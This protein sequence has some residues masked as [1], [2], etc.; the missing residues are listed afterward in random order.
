[1]LLRMATTDLRLEEWQSLIFFE[2]QRP[3]S[4]RYWPALICDPSTTSWPVVCSFSFLGITKGGLPWHKHFSN[5]GG[6]IDEDRSYTV[7]V[8]AAL[9]AHAATVAWILLLW[10]PRTQSLTPAGQLYPGGFSR[11]RRPLVLLAGRV[12]YRAS[13]PASTSIVQQ[14]TC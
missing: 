5:L 10:L 12:V 8:T 2:P 1:M 11:V 13:F 6:K 3:R 14:P 7:F 4:R 9:S